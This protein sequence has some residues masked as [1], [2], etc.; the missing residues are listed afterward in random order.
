VVS[1]HNQHKANT[2][3]VVSID[4]VGL[5]LYIRNQDRFMACIKGGTCPEPAG[6]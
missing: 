5:L 3:Q 1:G 6:T 4:I 2:I